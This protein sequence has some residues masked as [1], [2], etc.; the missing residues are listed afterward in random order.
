MPALLTHKQLLPSVLEGLVQLQFRSGEEAL[1]T[2]GTLWGRGSGA[3]LR[4]GRG[5]LVP[6]GTGA[7]WPAQSRH[8]RG[9]LAPA[10]PQ[11]SAQPGTYGVG[12]G[13]S[14]EFDQVA[15]QVLLLHELL[16]AG[17]ALENR[18]KVTS[19]AASTNGILAPLG[20]QAASQRQGPAGDDRRLPD[21]V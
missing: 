15:L 9:H 3:R 17:G 19:K 10:S 11:S 7:P 18:P 20:Y 21:L 2:G 12:L 13:G 16:G 5:C 6:H 4:T 14:V 1:G 8:G